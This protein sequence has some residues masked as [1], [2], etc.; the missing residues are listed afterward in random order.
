MTA[1]KN[2]PA[3][4]GVDARVVLCDAALTVLMERGIAGLDLGRVDDRAGVS[5][6]TC[7]RHFHSR[8]ALVGALFERLATLYYAEFREIS[9]RFPD[10]PVDCMVEWLA[11]I[12][13]PVRQRTQVTWAMLLDPGTRVQAAMYVDALQAG[14]EREV[15]DRF[16]LTS[17]QAHLAWPMVE[18][19]VGRTLVYREQVPERDTLAALLRA[20][21]DIVHT[22][23]IAHHGA[24]RSGP[25][26]DR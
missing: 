19:W 3:G 25:S 17:E 8:N 4:S 5:A 16:G 24:T 10:D 26:D 15:A 2:A 18:G 12:L 9:Q 20:L 6:G 1:L 7:R 23:R 21:L 13:G 22:S 11:H 14:W